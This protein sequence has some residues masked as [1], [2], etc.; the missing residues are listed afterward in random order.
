MGRKILVVEDTAI[1]RMMLKIMLEKEGYTIR[2]ASDG[3][4]AIEVYNFSLP[5]LVIL[6]HPLP[7]MSGIE[8]LKEIKSINSEAVCIMC[9]STRANQIV[10]EAIEAGAKDVIIRPFQNDR[11]LEAVRKQ[12]G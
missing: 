8:L 2:E 7:D 5:D 11:L 9:S 4:N 10:I 6:G 12:I 1:K 3:K